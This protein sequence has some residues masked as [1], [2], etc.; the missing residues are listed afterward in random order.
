MEKK[1][2]VKK[3]NNERI[4]IFM[5]GGQDEDGKNMMCVEIDQDIYIIEAGIKFPDPKESLGIECITQDLT[6]LIENKDRVAGVFITHGHDDVMSGL[7]YL[8]E[9]VPTHLYTSPLCAKE[10]QRKLKK[11]NVKGS[12]IHTIKRHDEKTIGGRKVV[13]FPVT[14]AYPNT[15]G[16]AISSNQGYILYTGEFIEDY[17]NLSDLYRG[18]FR[19]L[20]QSE[21]KGIFI[22]LQ[23]SKGADR[24]GH[25]APNH[26]LYPRVQAALEKHT[27]RRLIFGVYTQSVY[28]IREI[29]E[30]C[31]QYNRKVYF[32]NKELK[33][34]IK[35]MQ[36][37]GYEVD[38][39]YIA[40]E[41][42][43]KDKK[44][45]IAVLVSKQGP[46]MF[47]TL[48]NI[49]NNEVED[50][51]LDKE[52][53]ICIAAPIIP[54]CE[55]VYGAMENEIYKAGGKLEN[56]VSGMSSMHP[57]VE[58][59]KMMLFLLRPKYYIPVKGEYRQLI[60]NAQV[61]LDMG[62]DAN[63][64]IVL[65]NGQVATFEKG[66][67]RSCRQEMELSD[68]LVDGNENWDMD[69]VVLKDRDILSTDGVMILAIGI[70]AKTKKIINGPDVQTRGLI[71]LKDA[72]YI[73]KDVAK[74]MEDTIVTAVKEKKYDNMSTRNDI[75][76]KV[77]KYLMKTTAKRP[78][79]LPV[80]MEIHR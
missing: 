34:M 21:Q 36:T 44:K 30:S 22:L 16:V 20:T 56:L 64:I 40:S 71:Y 62:Y 14:H 50:F 63:H 23:E 38:A 45:N 37:V 43:F 73:T 49:V 67:L 18:D 5:L 66:R 1:K 70:D 79:V 52:D 53:V 29:I 2:P 31:I 75:R 15:F 54:G 51:E 47:R 35:D 57:S 77:I 11:H 28:R 59:L 78:M 39:K 41:K 13:F 60:A 33:T 58:D 76:D 17:D 80:I 9:Q 65:D 19:A 68:N 48:N 3:Q 12:S 32:Y 55:K 8:L 46:A 61:A 26:R 25:T 7:P 10:I 4:R 69:G 6:Y 42:D 27:N 72:E 24:S 74:I